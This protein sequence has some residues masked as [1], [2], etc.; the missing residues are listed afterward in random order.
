MPILVAVRDL[1]F[2]SRIQ[3]AADR[4]GIPL[5]LAP[6]DAP[7]ADA[8]RALGAGTVLAD[9]GEPGML[10]ALRAAKAAAPVR[11]V[12][13]LGHLQTDLARAATEAGV[14]EV[15]SRGELVQR[16]DALLASAQGA[17]AGPDA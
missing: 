1:L 3:A 14:D 16:L 15:L 12:G 11:I 4:L 7:L 17:S 8:A 9:L 6:R 5:R 10:D 13:F 2:R